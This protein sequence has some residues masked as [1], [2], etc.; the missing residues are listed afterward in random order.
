LQNKYHYFIIYL[1]INL[2]GQEKALGTSRKKV[3]KVALENTSFNV[4]EIQI[5]IIGSPLISGNG[6]K[7]D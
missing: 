4:Q 2:L 6:R 1:Y 7:N 5:F 3:E